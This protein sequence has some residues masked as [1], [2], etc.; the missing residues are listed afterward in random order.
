MR[1][2]GILIIDFSFPEEETSRAQHLSLALYSSSKA[3]SN[4]IYCG[5]ILNMWSP[6]TR[7]NFFISIHHWVLK[8]FTV[9][10]E[11]NYHPTHL[12]HGARVQDLVWHRIQEAAVGP[13]RLDQGGQLWHSAQLPGAGSLRQDLR[14]SEEGQQRALHPEPGVGQWGWLW[15]R[16]DQRVRGPFELL[17]AELVKLEKTSELVSSCLSRPFRKEKLVIYCQSIDQQ[18]VP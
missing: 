9:K 2:I 12:Q 1:E 6:V 10:Q 14:G 16:R 8:M 18:S 4:Q 7:M 11:P 3:E 17:V 13:D 5:G 15:L